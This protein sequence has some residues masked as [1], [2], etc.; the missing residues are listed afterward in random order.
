MASSSQKQSR[1]EYDFEKQAS[2]DHSL[3]GTVMQAILREFDNYAQS[4]PENRFPIQQQINRLLGLQRT[5]RR[6]R[7]EFNT[8]SIEE[9]EELLFEARGATFIIYPDDDPESPYSIQRRL[10]H[11][12][13]ILERRLLLKELTDTLPE[14]EN[15]RDHRDFIQTLVDRKL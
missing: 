7:K 2:F 11:K 6:I 14:V 15:L 8:H 13:W 9:Y 10:A 4:A 1:P 3:A 12:A 5:Y